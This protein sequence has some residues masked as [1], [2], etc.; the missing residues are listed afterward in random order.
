VTF[1]RAAGDAVNN[2]HGVSVRAI[3]TGSLF[4]FDFPQ[5]LIALTTSLTLFAVRLTT[6]VATARVGVY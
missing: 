2:V 4:S 3:Q 5:L 6:R 1:V